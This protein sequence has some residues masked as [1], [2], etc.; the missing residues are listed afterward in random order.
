MWA[1][2]ARTDRPELKGPSL[3]VLT[4]SQL[5]RLEVVFRGFLGVF[6]NCELLCNHL[7]GNNPT[8]LLVSAQQ[9]L[10]DS[11]RLFLQ[12]LIVADSWPNIIIVTTAFYLGIMQG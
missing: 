2:A 10:R 1:S 5:Y 8:S 9:S 11:D 3:E 7:G 12:R 4:Y 6:R